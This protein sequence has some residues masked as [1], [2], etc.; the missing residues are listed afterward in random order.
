MSTKETFK[1]AAVLAAALHVV[2]TN[3]VFNAAECALADIAAEY[4]K[5]CAE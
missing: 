3:A 1:V 4:E 5:T 2:G